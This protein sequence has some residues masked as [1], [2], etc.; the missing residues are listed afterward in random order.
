MR[1]K[2]FAACAA[3]LL[4]ACFTLSAHAAGNESC[5]TAKTTLRFESLGGNAYTV[6]AISSD[7]KTAY[8]TLPNLNCTFLRDGSHSFFCKGRVG[9][10]GVVLRSIFSTKQFMTSENS[11]VMTAPRYS[12]LAEYWNQNTIQFDEEMLA[13]AAP[14]NAV[15][16]TF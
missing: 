8:K 12:V 7:T 1:S 5:V 11:P 2:L 6:S 14:L 15:Q 9:S 13:V 10:H 16:C 3:S 4:A